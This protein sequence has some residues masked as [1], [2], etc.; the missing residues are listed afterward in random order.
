MCAILCIKDLDVISYLDSWENMLFFTDNRTKTTNDELW[1]LEHPPVF[2]QGQAG[3]SEHILNAQDYN[4]PIIQTDRGGQVTYHGPGQLVVYLLLDL[5]RKNIGIKQLINGIEQSIIN[6]LTE[7]NVI[8]HRKSNAPGV[9]VQEAKIASIGLRVRRG[10]TFHGLA[11]NINN[12]L[13]PFTYINPCGYK[14]LK[15]TNLKLCCSQNLSLK[16]V[17]HCFIKHFTKVL[18]YKV[19]CTPPTL[20]NLDECYE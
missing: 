2:T 14:N 12:D 16:C 18:D 4:I 10:C 7:Y 6:T 17:G 8:G 11:I 13:T 19:H 3:K 20:E 15:I 5:K 1:I 9:Y